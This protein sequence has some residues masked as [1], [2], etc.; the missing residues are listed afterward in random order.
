MKYGRSVAT[1]GAEEILDAKAV[2]GSDTLTGATRYIFWGVLGLV[3][4]GL[5]A[6]VARFAPKAE[7]KE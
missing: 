2:A 4:V 6:V 7:Q 3:V 5:L 1:T